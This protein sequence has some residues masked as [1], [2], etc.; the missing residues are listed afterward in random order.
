M[1]ERLYLNLLSNDELFVIVRHLSDRP[2]TDTWH[3]NLNSR[4]RGAIF[5]KDGPFAETI[6]EH[7]THAR[8]TESTGSRECGI[9]VRGDEKFGVTLFKHFGKAFK[10]VTIADFGLSALPVKPAILESFERNCDNLRRLSLHLDRDSIV[11]YS[12]RSFFVRNVSHLEH[13]QLWFRAAEGFRLILPKFPNLKVLSV[14][15]QRLEHATP[16]LES[17]ATSLR[18]IYLNGISTNWDPIIAQLYRCKSLTKIELE[19]NVPQDDYV[20]L[21]QS[22]GDNLNRAILKHMN[23]DMCRQIVRTCKNLECSVTIS[24]MNIEKMLIFGEH[25][26]RITIRNPGIGDW[27]QM[28]AAADI[29]TNIS[30]VQCL[31]RSMTGGALQA[32]FNSPKK[33][34]QHIHLVI[35]GLHVSTKFLDSIRCSTGNLRRLNL[36]VHVFCDMDALL[37][38][39]ET[40]HKLVEVQL[41]SRQRV[42]QDEATRNCVKIL[43]S[44]RMH[45]DLRRIA[46][47][48]DKEVT[49]RKQLAAV[50]REECEA[51]RFR[52]IE[53]VI[54]GNV[55]SHRNALGAPIH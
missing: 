20:K 24:A 6:S 8:I 16:L 45:R 4:T 37:Q 2:D 51:F 55:Y 53:I 3:A 41:N 48:F 32:L 14:N 47:Y 19:G 23:D 46:L 17:S 26:R 11:T 29:C 31:G 30:E 5:T 35:S 36:T 25:I 40:N 44:L 12:K 38:L 49:S 10:R 34:L 22:F 13:F 54:C 50:F 18:E 28:K 27:T 7:F 9:Y 52:L 42:S 43:T 1:G 15:G 39:L 21:L 33:Q